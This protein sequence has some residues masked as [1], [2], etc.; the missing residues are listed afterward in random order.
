MGMCRIFPAQTALSQLI[1]KTKRAEFLLSAESGSAEKARNESP[2]QMKES[3]A[4]F[5]SSRKDQFISGLSHGLGKV[6]DNKLEGVRNKSPHEIW[7]CFARSSSFYSR[8]FTSLAE[9]PSGCRARFIT[10]SST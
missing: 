7:V 9:P 3:Q 6:L 1:K 2:K 5:S 8:M 4:H 10:V